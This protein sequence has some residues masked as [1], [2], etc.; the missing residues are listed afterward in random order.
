MTEWSLS[1]SGVFVARDEIAV[2][3]SLED[4]RIATVEVEVGDHVVAGQVLLTLETEKLDNQLRETEGQ[5]A[6][7]KAALAQQEASLKQA[8]ANLNR[9]QLLRASETI[10]EQGYDERV[11][12]VAIA[13]QGA[14]AERAE[15]AQAEARYAEAQRERAR[16][17][18]LAPAAGVVSERQARAGALAGSD[19]LVRLIRG[20]VIELAAEVPE[21]ELPLV[22]AKQAARVVLPNGNVV[23]GRVRWISPKIDRE[24]RLG[25]AQIA[26]ESDTPLFPG[27]FGRAEIVIAKREAMVIAESALFY[28]ALPNDSSVFTVKDNRV[29]KQTVKI[30]LR[31]NGEVEILAGLNV[32]DRVVAKAAASLRAGDIVRAIDISTSSESDRK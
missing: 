20:G 28:G 5:V 22:E 24:T 19:P 14:A 17:V 27:T 8:Q 23:H 18:V 30:G 1:F 16:A 9:A 32:G 25:I 7:A 6:R 31:K 2:G 11:A 10:T 21:S 13:Q 15:H 4:Q 3:T 29:I 12:A 26:L